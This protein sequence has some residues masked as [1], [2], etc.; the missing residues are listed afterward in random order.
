MVHKGLFQ[1]LKLSSVCNIHLFL[2]FINRLSLHHSHMSTG[3]GS[4]AAGACSWSFTSTSFHIENEWGHKYE[5]NPPLF[6]HGQQR[7]KFI[8][9]MFQHSRQYYKFY[10][11]IILCYAI[12]WSIYMAKNVLNINIGI[13]IT[14]KI[15]TRCILSQVM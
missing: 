13:F 11:L 10:L 15:L 9:H 12:T 1:F 3:T 2:G 4:K 5:Y 7:D 8:L 14:N 6:L